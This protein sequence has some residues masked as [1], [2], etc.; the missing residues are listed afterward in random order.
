MCF[1]KLSDASAGKAAIS[2]M[3]KISSMSMLSIMA[4]AGMRMAGGV[5]DLVLEEVCAE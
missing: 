4:V 5:S 2:R 3:Q 1:H